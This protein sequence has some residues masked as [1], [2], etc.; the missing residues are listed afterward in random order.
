MPDSNELLTK[1]VFQSFKHPLYPRRFALALFFALIL[2]PL[3]AAGLAAG[4]VVLVVP[5]FALLIW[6]SG[7]VMY[8]TFLGHSILVSELNYSRIHHIGEE[9]KARIGYQK[10]VDIFVYEQGNF[11]AY[12]YKFFFFRRA[13]FLNSELL[14]AG[15]T[16][17]ELRWLIGRFIGYLKARREAGFW[18]WT[19]RAA[20]HL[21]IFN[22]FILPYERALVYTGDRIALGVIA[23]DI[24]S[25][26]SAMQK[27][28]VG[29]QLG[30]SVNPSGIVDQHRLVKGSLFALLARLTIAYP[31]MTARY[32]DLIGFARKRYPEQYQRFDAA[33]P[34][35][36]A[37]LEQLTALPNAGPVSGGDPFFIPL[38]A[39]LTILVPAVYFIVKDVVPRLRHTEPSYNF[40][41]TSTP[42]TSDTTP[43]TSGTVGT[44]STTT[45][46]Q[47]QPYTSSDGH[48]SIQFSA[49]PTESSSSINLANG[50]T[51]TLY[52]SILDQGGVEFLVAYCDYPAG[53]LDSDPQT[54]LASFRDSIVKSEK[55]TI[56]DDEAIDLSGVPGRAFSFTGQDG[57]A[58]TVRDYLSGQRLYQIIV[59][60]SSGST[61]S[62]VDDFLN[63]FR[64]Q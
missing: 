52:Q 32:V 61:A 57:T 59:T 16:D 37:D 47:A 58:Y 7:R 45:T 54:A 10:K 26:V 36:P 12:L 42:S 35:L 3:I 15:V 55:G 30:Y 48:Y 1:D 21:I 50:G 5:L 2:F 19:I 20:Q 14:E 6:M 24:S 27:L 60:A 22:F 25:A 9:L 29:R 17:D 8:S 44:G 34:G 31:A 33:N 49:A 62:G 51:T 40:D 63:S 46:P 23:G 64:I 41:Q 43:A 28:F 53:Y 56:S 11:N 18:G 38:V 4:T 39:A 13:V